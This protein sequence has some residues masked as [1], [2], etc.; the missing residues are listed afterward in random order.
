[1]DIILTTEEIEDENLRMRLVDDSLV[2][3]NQCPTTL[4]RKKLLEMLQNDNIPPTNSTE[5][6]ENRN[7]KNIPDEIT[8]ES[9]ITCKR[10][11]LKYLPTKTTFYKNSIVEENVAT[12]LSFATPLLILH[13][14]KDQNWYY[15]QCSFYRGWI[16]KEAI[17]KTTEQER[18]N[19]ECPDKFV[20]ITKPHIPLF[21]TYLDLGIKLPVLGVHPTF[22]EIFIPTKNGIHIQTI[23]KEI[24]HLGYL[25]YTKENILS[26]AYQCIDIPYQWGGIQNG[27][28]CS[29]FLLCLFQ[30]F[31]FHFPRDTKNQEETIGI[32]KIDLKGKTEVEK[33][34]IL[35][36]ITYP[37]ILHKKGHVLLAIN[38][39]EVIHAYGEAGKVIRSTLECYGTN[40]YSFLTS[41]SCLIR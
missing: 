14:S 25:P 6:L 37:A 31:G 23:S 11:T 16:L 41:I 22:Y 32:H 39:K 40:L 35:E 10:T 34:E 9:G 18:M 12:E 28:D 29:L 2:L 20:V 27:I 36:I 33:K 1:M 15:I 30:T 5:I 8:I 3:L 38:S 13:Q 19:F 26:L 7:I 24:C 17:L 4:S 21:N